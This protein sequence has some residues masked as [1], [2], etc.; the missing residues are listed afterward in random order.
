M[1]R[2]SSA[3]ASTTGTSM[4][5]TSTRFASLVI[6]QSSLKGWERKSGPTGVRS[7]RSRAA[8]NG[9]R[10]RHRELTALRGTRGER[11]RLHAGHGLIELGL[12]VGPE[13]ALRII[14][15]RDADAVVRRVEE[16]Q[17]T[18]GRAVGDADD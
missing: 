16:R 8:G 14:E 17:A 3:G 4:S 9:L 7:V 2:I 13:L 12:G 6:S 10:L 15:R 11:T 5:G 1:P 18:L